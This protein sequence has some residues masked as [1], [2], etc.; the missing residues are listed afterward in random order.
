MAEETVTVKKSEF[1][2]H[3]KA[4]TKASVKQVGSLVP[5]EFWQYGRE[6]RREFLLAMR[7]VV[8]GAIDRLEARGTGEAPPAKPK[9]KARKTRVVVEEAPEESEE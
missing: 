2:K 4:A 9:P 6:A 1:S 7:S 3:M 5:R 8:D